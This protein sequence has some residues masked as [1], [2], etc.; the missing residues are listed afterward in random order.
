MFFVVH[1]S[2]HRYEFRTQTRLRDRDV[3]FISCDNTLYIAFRWPAMAGHHGNAASQDA[4][5][6][7]MTLPPPNAMTTR[8]EHDV[9]MP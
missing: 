5:C 9:A 1:S 4:D 6:I 8:H 3:G 2:E 7:A